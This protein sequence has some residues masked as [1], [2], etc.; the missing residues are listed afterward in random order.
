MKF[1]AVS[2]VLILSA[3][4]LMGTPNNWAG[5]LEFAEPA[6]TK[7]VTVLGQSWAVFPAGGFDSV[8]VAQRDN[9]DLNPYGAPHYRR[10]PQAIR[11]IELA[12]GCRVNRS[13]IVQN[14][15]A[16]YFASVTCN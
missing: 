2:A 15:T 4:G 11:A 5:Q 13:D 9:L 16:R 8:Y 6:G 10:T 12:T 1:L 3:C 7:Y 14:I